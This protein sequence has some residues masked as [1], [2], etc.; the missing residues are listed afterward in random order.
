M[1]A[2]VYANTRETNRKIAKPKYFLSYIEIIF[3]YCTFPNLFPK[4]SRMIFLIIS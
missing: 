4:M 3:Y 1:I 2:D